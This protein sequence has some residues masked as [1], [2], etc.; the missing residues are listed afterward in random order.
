MRLTLLSL[1][2]GG[3]WGSIAEGLGGAG[4]GTLG[5]S[6][7]DTSAF[8]VCLSATSFSAGGEGRTTSS[9]FFLDGAFDVLLPDFEMTATLV[10][11]T[12]VSPSLATNYQ[13][14]NYQHCLFVNLF[15]FRRNLGK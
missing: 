8:D 6:I 14:N 3:S 11:G 15:I 1:S 10:P 5:F 13:N 12:T 4:E 9:A 2:L 7:L